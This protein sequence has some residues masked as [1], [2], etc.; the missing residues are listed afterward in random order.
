VA[1]SSDVQSLNPGLLPTDV[2]AE[3]VSDGYVETLY[4]IQGV[5]VPAGGIVTLFDLDA[6]SLGDNTYYFHPGTNELRNNVVWTTQNT[7]GSWTAKSYSAFPIEAFGFESTTKGSLPRPTLRIANVTGLIGALTREVSDLIGAKV[8]RRRTLVRYLDAANFAAST[9]PNADP[10]QF[11]PLDVFYINRKVAENRV[12]IE[13]EL[14]SAMDLHGV[15]LPR[16]QIIQNLCTWKYRSSECS[17]AGSNYFNALDATVTT[18]AEDVCS[19]RLS[20]CK[21][22]FGDYATL[23]YGGFPGAALDM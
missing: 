5:S 14:A 8:T 11:F 13:F 9:N 1:L 12:F 16:R 2:Y 22:R 20:G 10:T 21:A 6:T 4:T 15:K 19:K 7:N 17:Y 18:L 3:Y 23:P